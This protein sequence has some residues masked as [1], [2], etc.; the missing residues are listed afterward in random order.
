[1]S[2][3]PKCMNTRN[4]SMS[5]MP[6][7]VPVQPWLLI[8]L[9][10][11][12][13]VSSF[14]FF[15]FLFFSFFSFFFFLFSFLLF[16][17]LLF[18]SLLFSSLLFSSF[19]FSFHSFSFLFFFF[20]FMQKIVVQGGR[21]PSPTPATSCTRMLRCSSA[22]AWMPRHRLTALRLQTLLGLVEP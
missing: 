6:R 3:L 21:G 11:Q 7:F 9:T 8:K 10:P 1:M 2:A 16:S 20:S 15:L 19:F 4:A 17:S 12:G 22:A 14:L 13:I 5:Y 18:S